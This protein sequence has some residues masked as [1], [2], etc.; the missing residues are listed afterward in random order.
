[1]P[2][3]SV[4]AQYLDLLTGRG[5]GE[6]WLKLRYRHEA[7]MRT[8]F[9]PAHGPHRTLHRRI[10]K[11]AATR[12]VYVGCA[13]RGTQRGDRDHIGQSWVLWAECDASDARSRLDS[14]HLP[15]N[16]AIASGII[17][18][19]LARLR[20]GGPCHGRRHVVSGA[21]SLRRR[22]RHEC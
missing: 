20:C 6:G 13:L 7:G 14:F 16:L 4:L 9:Y 2:D 10:L 18:S 8:R 1:M 12:D 3:R 15:P 21:D 17:R 22:G 5:D 19:G 11:L